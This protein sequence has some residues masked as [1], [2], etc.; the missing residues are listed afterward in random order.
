[1]LKRIAQRTLAPIV[2]AAGGGSPG[3]RGA[4]VF[5]Y[6]RVLPGGVPNDWAL[7]SLIVDTSEF[8]R[9]MRWLV[10]RFTVRTARDAILS[11][12][13]TDRPLAAITFDDGYRD[14]A[15]YAAP[16]LDKLGL[17]ATFFVTT[18]FIGTGRRLWFDVAAALW[19][20]SHAANTT[21]GEFMTTLKRMTP[22]QRNAQLARDTRPDDWAASARDAAMTWDD[23]ATL[24]A[25]GHEIG[26]H[27]RTHP[28]LTTLS[29]AELE[30]EVAGAVADLRARNLDA[31]GL[32]YPNGD[33]NPAVIAAATRAG[34]EYAVTTAPGQ[35][36]R[37]SNPYLVRR[38]DANPALFHRWSRD[39]A[40]GLETETAWRSLSRR[41]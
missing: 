14:N 9:Q 36:D 7:A 22:A 40:R 27:S 6:H 20:R 31:R 4:T 30:D 11:D 38:I 18:G 25:R 23:V 17:R 24:H 15:L 12:A 10:E 28:V 8:E 32:A 33:H 1:M 19:R 35:Y 2:R 5:M 34:L 16:I 21:L 3:E 41:R 37:G 13:P 39:P 26:C 29:P